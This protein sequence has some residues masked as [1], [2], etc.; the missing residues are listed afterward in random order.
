M[1]RVNMLQ[2]GTK[3]GVAF[4]HNRAHSDFTAARYLPLASVLVALGDEI[5]N[6]RAL[7]VFYEFDDQRSPS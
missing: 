1:S 7:E 3:K 6:P 2:C 5:F 4:V